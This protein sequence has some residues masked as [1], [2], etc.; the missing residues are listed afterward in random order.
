MLQ[1]SQ[2][3]LDAIAAEKDVNVIFVAVLNKWLAG[4]GGDCTKKK[5]LEVLRSE[6]IRER[7][8]AAQIEE[9][10]GMYILFFHYFVNFC[11]CSI[12]I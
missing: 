9:N 2:P 4:A 1:I 5:L 8:L 12:Y 11:S 3:T 6:C 10:N 7:K